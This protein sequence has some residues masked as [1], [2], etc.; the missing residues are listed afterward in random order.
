MRAR[1]D[2]LELGLLRCRRLPALPPEPVALTERAFQH[3]QALGSVGVRRRADPRVVL[4]AS[5]MTE[6]QRGR[7]A[8]RRCSWF[9]PP[10]MADG[11]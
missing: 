3:L 9:T 6:V 10:T 7:H 8:P 2:E 4:E 11:S 5:G 1:V